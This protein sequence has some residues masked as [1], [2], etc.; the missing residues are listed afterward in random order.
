MISRDYTQEIGVAPAERRVSLPVT[1][2]IF[3]VAALAG[4]M[5]VREVYTPAPAAKAP[6]PPAKVSSR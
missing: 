2:A 1:I 6:P 5:I 4:V 3:A